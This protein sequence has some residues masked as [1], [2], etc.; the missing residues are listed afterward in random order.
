[1]GLV[2]VFLEHVMRVYVNAKD[3]GGRT[4]LS[5][6]AARGNRGKAQDVLV[7]NMDNQEAV[8]AV[9]VLMGMVRSM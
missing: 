1:M 6:A 9:R 5:W 4:P 3:N 8:H 2:E 7:T